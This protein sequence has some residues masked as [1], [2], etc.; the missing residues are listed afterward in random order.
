VNASPTDED[1]LVSILIPIF[2]IDLEVPADTPIAD[3]LPVLLD[4]CRKALDGITPDDVVL[5]RLDRTDPSG[6]PRTLDARSSFDAQGVVAGDV[7]HLVPREQDILV[8]YRP[9]DP[10]SPRDSGPPPRQPDFSVLDKVGSVLKATK[11]TLKPTLGRASDIRSKL[12]QRAARALSGAPD[13]TSA[14]GT[15]A[16]WTPEPEAPAPGETASGR[17]APDPAELGELEVRRRRAND[18]GEAGRPQ[19]AFSEFAAMLAYYS[20]RMDEDQPE[21]LYLRSGHAHWRAQ[22]G[23]RRE[24]VAEFEQ[25]LHDQIRVFGATDSRVTA[26]RA[27]LEYWRGLVYPVY[28]R[29][30]GDQG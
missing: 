15:S 18:L 1:P 25:V 19:A 5:Q 24:A 3:L 23:Q 10:G 28:R 8:Q 21:I 11:P 6:E 7:L 20:A 14:P 13:A 26:T 9:R 29:D 30:A 22:T 16:P 17:R 4:R 12:A 27:Q 2:R